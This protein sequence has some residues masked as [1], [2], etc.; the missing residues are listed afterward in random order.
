MI[1]IL[2]KNGPACPE[3][4][5]RIHSNSN[6]KNFPRDS[7]LSFEIIM[8]DESW[9]KT[10]TGNPWLEQD[11]GN[12]HSLHKI[13]ILAMEEK[14]NL[15]TACTIGIKMVSDIP[16]SNLN[17]NEKFLSP[18]SLFNSSAGCQVQGIG[19]L[20]LDLLLQYHYKCYYN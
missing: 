5:V 17:L 12:W 15:H 11:Q 1:I 20:H 3:R 6:V 16:I 2:T 13:K 19:P 14:N 18:S 8:S 4:F 7:P 9:V 10:T